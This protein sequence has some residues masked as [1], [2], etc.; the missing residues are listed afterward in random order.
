[1]GRGGAAAGN[2]GR[3]SGA[4]STQLSALEKEKKPPFESVSDGKPGGELFKERK[5]SGRPVCC[6]DKERHRLRKPITPRIARLVM[7]ECTARMVRAP[8]KFSS[9]SDENDKEVAE[10]DAEGG[11]PVSNFGFYAVEVP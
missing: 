2:P 9:A 7:K 8:A 11:P 6:A 10:A 5:I 1:M 3:K 4:G